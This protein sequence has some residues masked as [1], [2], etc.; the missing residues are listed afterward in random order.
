MPYTADVKGYMSYLPAPNVEKQYDLVSYSTYL[1]GK[2]GLFKQSI[3][4][5]PWWSCTPY[6]F[7]NIYFG[8]EIFTSVK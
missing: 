5:K 2:I 6:E 7:V 3:N 4:C 8:I 1:F